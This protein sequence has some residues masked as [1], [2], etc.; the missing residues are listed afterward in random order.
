M[1]K[2]TILMLCTLLAITTHAAPKPE[3]LK[4]DVQ[5]YFDNLFS[6]LKTAAEQKP[7]ED[8]FR[9]IMKPLVKPID[10]F[11][12]ATL[13]D[14]NFVIRQV[15]HRRNFLAR[16]F[17]LKKVDQ[18][19]DFWA[20]MQQKPEPQLS[21][22]GHGSLVQPRLIAMRYPILNEKGELTGIVSL[23]VKT[24]AFLK[25]VHLDD[26]EAYRITCRGTLAEEE[27]T[28]SDDYKEITLELPSTTWTIQYE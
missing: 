3:Q 10:G 15:Y 11:F 28:L 14:T 8:S 20:M 26:V 18:L 22:P 2:R 5:G 25:A 23:M 24:E 13:V 19:T 27:G 6:S 21:E 7:T 12:G 17:D 1:I 16:G 9:G 4:A